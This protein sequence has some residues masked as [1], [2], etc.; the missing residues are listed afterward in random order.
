M[1]EVLNISRDMLLESEYI[2][3]TRE[4]INF[5]FRPQ[6]ISPDLS[7]IVIQLESYVSDGT[8]Y[9]SGGGGG[10]GNGN[11]L[12]CGSSSDF[13]TTDDDPP[14][15]IR[16]SSPASKVNDGFFLQFNCINSELDRA[17]ELANMVTLTIMRSTVE[18]VTYTI[19][20]KGILYDVDGFNCY[21]TTKA[22]VDMSVLYANDYTD[23]ESFPIPHSVSWN[24][25]NPAWYPGVFYYD[26]GYLRDI[27]GNEL[28]PDEYEITIPRYYYQKDEQSKTLNGPAN[29]F[30]DIIEGGQLELNT[31]ESSDGA[32]HDVM[33]YPYRYV[34]DVDVRHK[35]HPQA[36][37]RITTQVFLDW[38]VWDYPPV[39]SAS[40]FSENPGFFPAF[41]ANQSN[42]IGIFAMNQ[43]GS[44]TQ[45]YKE[46]PDTGEYFQFLTIETQ[47]A[48][49]YL[50]GELG[51]YL[52]GNVNM[53]ITSSPPD[54]G[55]V[56]SSE[57]KWVGTLDLSGYAQETFLGNKFKLRY[58]IN[59]IDH[60]GN[61]VLAKLIEN[62]RTIETV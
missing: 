48:Q 6:G 14:Q 8:R 35:T 55:P 40:V 45:S 36:Y 52:A 22:T 37:A 29:F 5:G 17:L 28:N 30:A 46:N 15:T 59:Y 20:D 49:L 47:S 58:T 31:N 53:A 50:Q 10:G 51:W 19:Q 42:D 38:S 39:V 61:I 33:D 43:N 56:N 62:E 41:Y 16:V 32:I 57:N 25:T 26:I 44:N 9:G 12:L 2:Q 4:F 27:N 60:L 23:A 13:I 24:L 34:F 7:S 3:L 1:Q 54:I 21:V 18:G 11:G